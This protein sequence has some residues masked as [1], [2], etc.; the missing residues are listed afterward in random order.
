M[1]VFTLKWV[2]F[3]DFEAFE[4]IFKEVK[5]F[6]SKSEAFAKIGRLLKDIEAFFN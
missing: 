4:F 1:E 5:A 3:K 2:V 6:V